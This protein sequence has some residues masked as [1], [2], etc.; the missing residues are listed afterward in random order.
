MWYMH[1]G[2]ICGICMQGM[3]AVHEWTC[4]QLV[5]MK[6]EPSLNTKLHINQHTTKRT[7][8]Q[9]SVHMPIRTSIY[10]CLIAVCCSDS[11]H[12]CIHSRSN[13]LCCSRC[14]SCDIH[15][16]IHS[17]VKC[18]LFNCNFSFNLMY[19]I[20]VCSSHNIHLYTLIHIYRI[21]I[22]AGPRAGTGVRNGGQEH[23]RSFP[24]GR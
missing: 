5:R 20:T 6:G 13:D 8:E 2:Y 7:N 24:P 17:C 3:H 12:P 1:V 14:S 11:I 23:D 16:Y 9:T 21:F 18:C 22:T 4:L 15:T 10:P 19:S